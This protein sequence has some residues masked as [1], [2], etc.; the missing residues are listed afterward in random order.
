MGRLADVELTLAQILRKAILGLTQAF[1]FNWLYFEIDSF[2]L[3]YHAIRR[4]NV[5]CR[6]TSPPLES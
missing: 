6:H 2:N 4:H 5:S 1:C 3:H